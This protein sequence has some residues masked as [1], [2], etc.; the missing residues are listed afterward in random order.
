M[1]PRTPLIAVLCVAVDA[2]SAQPALAQSVQRR[3]WAVAGEFAGALG[4]TWLEST[5]APLVT[6]TTGAQLSLSANRPTSAR[7][8]LGAAVRVSA[9][10]LQL[11]EAGASWSGGTLTTAQ[12]LG[13]MSID[14]PHTERVTPAI[15]VGGGLSV[16]SGAKELLPFST[17]S[18]MAPAGEVGISVRRTAN[19]D[20]DVRRTAFDLRALAL[21]VRYDVTR[22]DPGS[23][24]P[25]GGV[26]RG[27]TAGWVGRLL[28]GVRVM[29]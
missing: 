10:S 17:A 26:P 20:V 23:S 6:T 8:A 14:L 13:T 5:G 4:G 19:T 24:A 2:L 25:G 12:V 11:Q 18:R 28:V 1:S 16:L 22:L 7:I 27:A 21:V 3:D 9:Q 15:E 29:R